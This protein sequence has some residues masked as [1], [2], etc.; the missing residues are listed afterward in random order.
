MASSP[1]SAGSELIAFGIL[2]RPHGLTG[3][4]SLRPFNDDGADLSDLPFPM[5]VVAVRG[6]N[7]RPLEL[8]AARPAGDVWLVKFVGVGDRDL[9]AGLTNTELWLP[10]EAL[11]PLDEDEIYVE[12]L[13]GCQVVDEQGQARGTIRSTFWNG[14]QEVLSVLSPEGQEV[15]LPAVPE[16]VLSVDL[17]ARTVV[18]NFHE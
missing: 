8:Q 3:E 14:A 2:G 15:L 1:D 4:V 17:E 6:E 10:R 13:V 18:V 12:D 11:P 7:R 16:F 5:K 9:A